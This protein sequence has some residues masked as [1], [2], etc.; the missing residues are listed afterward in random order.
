MIISK[1]L[2]NR[3]LGLFHGAAK[4]GIAGQTLGS[5]FAIQQLVILMVW[6]RSVPPY[7]D[8]F[9]MGK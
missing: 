1:A 7:G 9:N 5:G 3:L 2:V 4:N 6:G 8:H